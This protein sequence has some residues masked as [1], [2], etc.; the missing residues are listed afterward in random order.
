VDPCR[1]S[2]LASSPPAAVDVTLLLKITGPSNSEMRW[3]S[4]PPSTLIDLEIVT[5]RGVRTSNPM[6][7]PVSPTYSPT[8]DGTGASNTPSCPVEE[9]TF[10]LPMKKSPSLFIPV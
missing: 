7:T 1:K 10:L 9:L 5:S 8:T 6:L 3:P 2:E 4:G